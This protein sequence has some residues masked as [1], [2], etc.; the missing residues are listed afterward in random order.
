MGIK[1]L[2]AILFLGTACSGTPE[3]P[4]INPYAIFQDQSDPDEN[5]IYA[6]PCRV[7]DPKQFTFKCKMSDSVPVNKL[8]KGY[9]MVSS[10]EIQSWRAWGK[11]LAANY[12]C[13]KK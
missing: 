7:S 1:F 11:D 12:E 8:F 5:H 4:E 9:F 3:P 6:M 2:I 10:Q 13:K